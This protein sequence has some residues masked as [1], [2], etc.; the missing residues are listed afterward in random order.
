MGLHYILEELP[1]LIQDEDILE[2]L[3]ISRAASSVAINIL[4]DLT[5]FDKI[6]EG[7]LTLNKEH[8]SARDMILTAASIFQAQARSHSLT[9][10]FPVA[11]SAVRY[12]VWM[13]NC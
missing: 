8:V 11:L 10:Y 13:T 12:S 5:T 7:V 9:Q 3:H 4:N 1:K 2:S 6:E